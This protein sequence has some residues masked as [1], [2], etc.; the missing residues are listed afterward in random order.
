MES[1]K[2]LGILR[3][4]LDEIAQP[5]SDLILLLRY[6]SENIEDKDQ[7]YPSLKTMGSQLDNIL[8]IIGFIYQKTWF[9]AEFM[10][11]KPKNHY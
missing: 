5:I 8:D 2:I 6:L 10:C 9:N 3:N 7:I 4:N 11:T 1:K